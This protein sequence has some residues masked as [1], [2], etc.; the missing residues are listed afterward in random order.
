M[1]T[2]WLE[3]GTQPAGWAGRGGGVGAASML[4]VCTAAGE[5]KGMATGRHAMHARMH[6][7]AITTPPLQQSQTGK[8]T[9]GVSSMRLHMVDMQP[10]A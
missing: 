1:D 8:S 3:P 4:Y 2:D 10:L 9:F 7:T 5:G 6:P